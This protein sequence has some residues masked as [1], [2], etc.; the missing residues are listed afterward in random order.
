MSQ[1]PFMHEVA[2]SDTRWHLGAVS[3]WKTSSSSRTGSRIHCPV[4]LMTV[5]IV[6]GLLVSE[7]S[8]GTAWLRDVVHL[9]S[10]HSHFI[11]STLTTP[12]TRSPWPEAPR[13]LFIA[14][15][16]AGITNVIESSVAGVGRD[17]RP[18]HHLAL[19]RS[20]LAISVCWGD[21]GVKPGVQDG[22][23]AH[24]AVASVVTSAP[25]MAELGEDA[26]CWRRTAYFITAA[27]LP[28]PPSSL[29]P[30]PPPFSFCD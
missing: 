19:R 29:P 10:S 2:A 16:S 13:V 5:F 1:Q 14:I 15:K 9:S 3:G 22:S 21:R 11:V 24:A 30:L 12:M 20:H 23:P 27:P 28:P 7:K 17:A 26:S 25:S 4:R 18:N 8:P 6:N